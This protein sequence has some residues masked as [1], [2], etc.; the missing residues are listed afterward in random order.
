MAQE[1]TVL[2]RGQASASSSD[3]GFYTDGA[4]HC[5]KPNWSQSQWEKDNY[6]MVSPICGVQEIVQGIIRE[7]GK[8]EWGKNQRWGQT[9]RDS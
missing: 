1:G 9:M 2:I 5:I 7:G 8:T 3:I 6:H 4:R